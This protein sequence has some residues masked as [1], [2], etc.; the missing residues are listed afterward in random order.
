MSHRTVTCIVVS[1]DMCGTEEGAGDND[2]GVPHFT[3]LAEAVEFWRRSDWIVV[4]ERFVCSTCAAGE[5]C[6]RMG[7]TWGGWIPTVRENYV[8]QFRYCDTCNKYEV[9]PPMRSGAAT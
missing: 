4:G 5:E 9:D 2:G 3:D 1:C 8:G 7:H 6:A